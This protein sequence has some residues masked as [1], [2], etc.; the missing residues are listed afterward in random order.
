MREAA[1]TVQFYQN[2]LGMRE[3]S[4]PYAINAIE[5]CYVRDKSPVT[6]Q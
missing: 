6:R 4:S 3:Y 5:R 1:E 2:I